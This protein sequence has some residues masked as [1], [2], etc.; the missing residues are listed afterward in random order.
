[1][2]FR[3]AKNCFMKRNFPL[4]MEKEIARFVKTGDFK[5]NRC[6]QVPLFIHNNKQ[7]R[8]KDQTWTDLRETCDRK[9]WSMIFEPQDTVPRKVFKH[10][11]RRAKQIPHEPFW[12]SAFHN[13]V[14][15]FFCWSHYWNQLT[16]VQIQAPYPNPCLL[17]T[18]P[19]F[20]QLL[21]MSLKTLKNLIHIQKSSNVIFSLENPSQN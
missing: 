5:E 9:I 16:T 18:K 12:F 8:D 21:V 15:L 20:S 17:N 19:D 2:D 1:M 7:C 13:T 6:I 11:K 3:A 14:Q 4:K 10:T